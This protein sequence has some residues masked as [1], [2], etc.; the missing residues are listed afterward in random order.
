MFLLGE[1]WLGLV[2][3][4]IKVF[5]RCNFSATTEKYWQYNVQC[6]YT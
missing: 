6:E 4:W 3:N 1:E 2:G 5:K